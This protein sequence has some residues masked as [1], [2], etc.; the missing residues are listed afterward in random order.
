[1]SD[2]LLCDPFLP[3]IQARIRQAFLLGLTRAPLT[4]PQQLAAVAAGATDPTL[5]LLALA[6]Q[7]QRFAPLPD[8]TADELPEA[9][10]AMHQDPRPI[11]P[12]E[13][14]RAFIRLISSVE[15]SNASSVIS[16]AAG[17]IAAAGFRLHPFDLPELVRHVRAEADRL[18]TS[19]RAYLALTASEDDEDATKGLFFA[20]IT[21]DNWTTFPKGARRDFLKD[22][23]R[24]DAEAA[25]ALLESIW[26]SESAPT[27]LTL[28]EALAINLSAN[29]KPFLDMLAKDRAETVRQAAALL[30]ARIP[31][32]TAHAERLAAAA[33]CF[34]QPSNSGLSAFVRGL[35]L[36]NSRTELR[37]ERPKTT[38]STVSS[39]WTQ[40]NAERE[41][42]FAGLSLEALAVAVEATPEAIV[43]AL[44]AEEHGVLIHFIDTAKASDDHALVQRIIGARLLMST[45]LPPHL[46][47]PLIQS[48]RTVLPQEIAQ[49]LLTS[50]Q[51][52]AA[53]AEMVTLGHTKDDGRLV[54]MAA[55][56]PR[57]VASGFVTTIAALAPTVTRGA[58]DFIE[59]IQS[60]PETPPPGAAA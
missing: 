58:R 7:R 13:A 57:A 40:L 37:F 46:L 50:P 52:L 5:A 36:S 44:P 22:Q 38:G 14:R 4:P 49:R 30:I 3:E 24:A 43:S 19:E 47:L 20:R 17:R 59:L 31:S 45:M 9:A 60:L 6:G 16:L 35:A 2:P 11:L 21:P 1:M 8:V 25:R 10:R 42:L 29:D 48:A 33:A 53:L 12:P 51:W 26:K 56:M 15:K 18:G 55:V 54:F 28:L 32:T 34:K 23:R 39:N 27:R 41:H